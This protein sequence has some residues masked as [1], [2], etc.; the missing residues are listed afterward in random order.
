MIDALTTLKAEND[1]L[2]AYVKHLETII[3]D[4]REANQDLKYQLVQN[5]LKVAGKID[6]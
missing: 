1:E 2:K 5:I 6:E 4:L 3:G